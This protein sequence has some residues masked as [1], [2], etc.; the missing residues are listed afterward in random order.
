MLVMSK[1]MNNPENSW[2]FD[3]YRSVL[4]IFLRFKLSFVPCSAEFAIPPQPFYDSLFLRSGRAGLVTASQL[5]LLISH[6][7]RFPASPEP[8]KP[9]LLM[10]RRI[11][12]FLFRL[13]KFALRKSRNERQKLQS[14]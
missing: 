12:F 6:F 9:R 2:N 4:K 1:F 5:R 11:Y 13:M 14:V 3:S 7:V 8:K 10:R